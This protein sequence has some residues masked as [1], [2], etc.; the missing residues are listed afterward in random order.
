MS[1]ITPWLRFLENQTA[2]RRPMSFLC[3][4]RHS[5][6]KGDYCNVHSHRGIEIVYHP[7]GSG[8][9]RTGQ[10]S[11]I[12]F[13]EGS[14]VIYPAGTPHDQ[15]MEASGEDLCVQVAVAGRKERLPD[16]CL[17]IPAINKQS[18][19]EDIRLPFPSPAQ[20]WV[21]AGARPSATCGPP[22]TLLELIQLAGNEITRRPGQ[23]RQQARPESAAIHPGA[24][25][26]NHLPPAD[27]RPCRYRPRPLA[28]SFQINHRQKPHPTPQ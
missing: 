7:F 19:I 10:N 16:K 3:G 22:A 17:Y 2:T 24:F 11:R 15:T 4:L 8:V 6:K 14:I 5:M 12:A 25:S 21:P 27:R 1:S 23:P 13:E 20:N 28:A 18:V 26:G 9:T